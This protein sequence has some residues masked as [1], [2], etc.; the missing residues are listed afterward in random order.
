MSHNWVF[1]NWVLVRFMTR[2]LHFFHNG[3]AQKRH[4][5]ENQL[6]GVGDLNVK[7]NW[8][9][10]Q[11]FSEH[12][13][14]TYGRRRYYFSPPLTSKI[15]AA[16]FQSSTVREEWNERQPWAI[17]SPTSIRGVVSCEY[18]GYSRH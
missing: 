8:P 11:N 14:N 7:I 2:L 13:F 18:H 10:S 15:N 3:L 12:A 1:Y 16:E 17:P 9:T 6:Q 5:K 4:I